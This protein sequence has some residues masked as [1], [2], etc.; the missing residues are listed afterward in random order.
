MCGITGIISFS[1]AGKDRLS[2]V[3]VS[4]DTLF[5][6]GPDGGNYFTGWG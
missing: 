6:R 5:H 2:K 1:P 3:K 4:A